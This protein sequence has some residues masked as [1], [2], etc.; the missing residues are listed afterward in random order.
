[1]HDPY[2]SNNILIYNNEVE[3]YYGKIFIDVLD[4]TGRVLS[5]ELLSNNYSIN[6]NHL[7][8]GLYISIATNEYGQILNTYK[9]YKN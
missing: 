3:L 1:M 9:F 8:A 2:L 6:L 7:A 5:H 4:L